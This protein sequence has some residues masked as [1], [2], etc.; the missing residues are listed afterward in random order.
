MPQ[1]IQPN[2]LREAKVLLK[3]GRVKTLE[4]ILLLAV[5]RKTSF[6]SRPSEAQPC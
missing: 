6:I 4:R 2:V 3:P 5:W 1:K